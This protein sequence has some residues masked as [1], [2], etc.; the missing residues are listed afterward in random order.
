VTALVA[1]LGPV[2]RVTGFAR[3]TSPER[4]VPRGPRRG[5][6]IPVSVPTHVTGS[7]ELESGVLVTTLM[8]WDIWSTNL[9]YLEVYGTE[10][11]LSVP[12]PDVFDGLPRVRR[13]GEEELRQPPPPPG[14]VEWT[15]MP[16][17]HDADIERGIGVADMAHGVRTG[18]P[19]RASGELAL[20]VLEVLTALHGA[21]PGRGSVEIESSCERPKPLPTGLLK[22]TLD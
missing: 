12:N 5:E 7:L 21:V 11:S 22:G 17:T 14:A 15:E 19:H 18:R 1:L 8:S 20:H 6:R 9:P 10:G 16:L 3:A 4:I 2:A 13:A